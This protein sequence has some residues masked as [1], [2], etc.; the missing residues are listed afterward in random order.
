MDIKEVKHAISDCYE[1]LNSI[2][3]RKSYISTVII[4]L[5]TV[6]FILLSIIV[7]K[8]FI[9]TNGHS[10]GVNSAIQLS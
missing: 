10:L 9:N 2:P 3:K 8:L 7:F 6:S 5:I 1:V 4:S